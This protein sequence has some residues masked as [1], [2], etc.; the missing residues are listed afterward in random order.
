MPVPSPLLAVPAVLVLLRCTLAQQQCPAGA[1]VCEELQQ[2]ALGA[3]PSVELL[4]VHVGKAPAAERAGAQGQPLGL[5]AASKARQGEAPAAST[6]AAAAAN[7]TGA[8]SRVAQL[9]LAAAPGR[10]TASANATSA[11]R[12]ASKLALA[13]L[14]TRTV[15]GQELQQ[16][17]GLS[18][19]IGSVAGAVAGA[20]V[21]AAKATALATFAA[22]VNSTLLL[23]DDKATALVN[24]SEALKESAFEAVTARSD[25]AMVALQAAVLAHLG[26]FE[27]VW[28]SITLALSAAVP[29]VTSALSTAGESDLVESL[30]NTLNKAL[31]QANSFTEVLANASDIL[32]R[33]GNATEAKEAGVLDS[34]NATLED[35][36]QHAK[37]FADSLEAGLE[38]LLSS[39]SGQLDQLASSLQ[40]EAEATLSTLMQQVSELV[41]KLEDAVETS[42]RS[43]GEASTAAFTAASTPPPRQS[44][45]A[46]GPRVQAV[47]LLLGL[48]PL[49]ASAPSA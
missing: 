1:G 5:A 24:Q 35:A 45:F 12:N 13:T 2:E 31:T 22:V 41:A 48:S 30:T 20:A 7:A 46:G 34:L 6:A 47:W 39:I 14:G 44:S 19:V 40:P 33:A 3:A 43:I 36:L 15:S 16:I 26:P 49:L 27:Q 42:V 11:L 9:A 32:A 23:L 21:S 38:A 10:A 18:D 4:Q 28:G 25:S 29:T 37:G 8:F 17:P